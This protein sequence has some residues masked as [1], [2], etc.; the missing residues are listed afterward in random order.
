MKSIRKAEHEIQKKLTE[1]DDILFDW[2][3]QMD[4][5]DGVML[6]SDVY[7]A[8]T[9]YADTL[10]KYMKGV[11]EALNDSLYCAEC[12]KLLLE[13]DLVWNH[14]HECYCKRCARRKHIPF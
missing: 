14:D 7:D 11:L 5:P 6:T 12:G 8:R 13:D 4:I 2:M 9:K 1:I 10:S 3:E